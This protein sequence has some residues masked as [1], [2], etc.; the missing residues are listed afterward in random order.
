MTWDAFSAQMARLDGLKFGPQNLHTHWEGL[1][2]LALPDLTRAIDHAVKGCASYPSPAELREL[3]RQT[4][5]TVGMDEDRSAPLEPPVT[6]SHP[7][8]PAPI[9]VTRTWNF[10]CG[11]CGDT[12]WVSYW[13]GASPPHPWLETRVCARHKDHGEHEFVR[14]CACRDTNPDVKR[15]AERQ[16]QFAAHR[17]AGGER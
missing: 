11:V 4:L 17:T 16:A 9:Q 2:D 5:P 13:C 15:R 14:P 3:A 1:S 6:I 12:G 8:L 10:Y 7:S